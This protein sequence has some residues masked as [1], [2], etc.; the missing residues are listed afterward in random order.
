[1]TGPAADETFI[2]GTPGDFSAAWQASLKTFRDAPRGASESLWSRRTI[3]SL[4]F[5]SPSGG[6]FL[7]S[8]RCL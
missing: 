1:L 2:V 7:S 6:S 5:E 4:L 8:K 3:V